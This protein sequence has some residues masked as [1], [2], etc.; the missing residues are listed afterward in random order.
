MW[1]KGP[2]SHEHRPP[3]STRSRE[4]QLHTLHT[5]RP[6]PAPTP[7]RIRLD[8]S[9]S[10][11]SW[12]K[13][14][15]FSILL[16]LLLTKKSFFSR[17]NLSTPSMFL[18]RLKEISKTLGTSKA[19]IN[20][21]R[22]RRAQDVAD[23]E[24]AARPGNVAGR[25]A[26]RAPKACCPGSQHEAED[27]NRLL[28]KELSLT[29]PVKGFTC[30]L[31]LWASRCP[32]GARH[33]PDRGRGL[34]GPSSGCRAG[35]GAAARPPAASQLTPALSARPGSQSSGSGCRKGPALG[36]SAAPLGSQC[37]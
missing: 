1:K 3:V 5:S 20:E 14:L 6:R 2:R 34:P 37:T 9:S 19:F 25:A 35:F 4:T 31:G 8:P 17:V 13:L 12:C 23:L 36:G 11:C 22:S 7:T 24:A 16:I 18:S 28:P 29:S 21:H 33:R 10:I 30:R 32:R 27:R 26:H 15:M